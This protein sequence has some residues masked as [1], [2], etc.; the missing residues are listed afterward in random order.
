MDKEQ[1]THEITRILSL[2]KLPAVDRPVDFGMS[3]TKQGAFAPC[4]V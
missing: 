1:V 2:W 3:T 4:F